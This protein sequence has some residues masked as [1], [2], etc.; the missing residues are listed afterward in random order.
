MILKMKKKEKRYLVNIVT[1]LY[2]KIVDY[3]DKKSG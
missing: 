1:E 2:K 3:F